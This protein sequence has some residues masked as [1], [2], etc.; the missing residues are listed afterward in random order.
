MFDTTLI[1]LD[2]G[3]TSI[4]ETIVHADFARRNCIEILH[5]LSNFLLLECSHGFHLL[6]CA[7]VGGTQFDKKVP[8]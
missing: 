8:L 2:V 6:F 3:E 5:H 7:E 4:Q 1:F